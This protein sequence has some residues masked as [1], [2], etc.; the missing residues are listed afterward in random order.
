MGPLQIN[1]SLGVFL[2]THASACVCVWGG[3]ASVCLSM[4]MHVGCVYT[5]MHMHVEAT[6]Q[7]Q[8]SFLGAL[9]SFLWLRDNAGFFTVA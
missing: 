4:C 6:E 2:C 5:C 1:R 7:P 3:S 8:L 9:A